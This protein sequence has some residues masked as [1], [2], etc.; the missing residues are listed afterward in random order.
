MFSIDDAQKALDYADRIGYPVVC[1]P[2]AGL[3]GIGVITDIGSRDELVKALDLYEK[4]QLGNDDFVIEQHVKGSDYRIV[5]IG[6]EVVAAVVREPASVL[7]NGVHTI[8]D[9]VEYK[10]RV[11]ALN[12]H[13]RSRPI[14]FSDAMRYQLAQGGLTLDSVPAAGQQVVLANSANLSQGGDSFEVVDELHPSIRDVAIRAVQGIPGLGFCGLDMLIEDHRK[15]I[16]QQSAT[17]IELNAHAAIGSAQYPMWGTPTPVAKLFFE[18]CA[19]FHDIELPPERADRLCVQIVVKGKV[20]KV[21]FRRWFKRRATRFGVYGWIRN[22]GRKEVTARLDGPAE[23]VAALVYLAILGPRKSGPTSVTTT[24][25]YP[26]DEPGFRILRR[27]TA[28]SV[29]GFAIRQVR[30]RALSFLITG[31]RRFTR[32]KPGS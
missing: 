2:V 30:R 7:G 21:S 20:T 24:H 3:R 6:E 25:S 26:V 29:R 16:D 10:N 8:V 18:Q 17:V 4:S 1:K 15:P 12:P 13:L 22:T 32:S 5:V 14:Q 11:R 9:L 19:R 27:S 23:A 28:T 31:Q